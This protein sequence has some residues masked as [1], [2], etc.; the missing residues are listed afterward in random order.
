[1]EFTLREQDTSMALQMGTAHFLVVGYAKANLDKS[2][3]TQK[4]GFTKQVVGVQ[5]PED[6]MAWK[7]D[8]HPTCYVVTPILD[9]APEQLKFY[10]LL[11]PGKG[12][13]TP[14]TLAKD[15]VFYRFE[16][17]NEEPNATKRRA[18]W[19]DLIA[20]QSV[21]VGM[22]KTPSAKQ[23]T[24]KRALNVGKVIVES[25][26]DFGNEM[27]ILALAF[28]KTG[29]KDTWIL[30][31]MKKL[32]ERVDVDLAYRPHR[33]NK[34]LRSFIDND[35]V[36]FDQE[37]AMKV[38]TE[39]AALWPDVR[40]MT[41]ER[42]LEL[43]RL[44]H[45]HNAEIK[46][47]QLKGLLSEG[48]HL[49][50]QQADGNETTDEAGFVRGLS[51]TLD[52]VLGE[53]AQPKATA[54]NMNAESQDALL[55]ALQGKLESMLSCYYSFSSQLS[56]QFGDHVLEGAGPADFWAKYAEAP[57]T[58]SARL[59]FNHVAKFLVAEFSHVL[60][61]GIV[62]PVHDMVEVLKRLNLS[63]N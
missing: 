57:D 22:Q 13:C 10:V 51:A 8:E 44:M 52:R 11:L 61:E 37:D 9:L 4:P 12:L 39:V 2:Y 46:A 25:H 16:Y 35:A 31:E 36:D 7:D 53:Q 50:G 29:L 21:R 49:L 38:V 55:A 3:R 5:A 42:V 47:F 20:Q 28:K 62:K 6:I 41:P 59:A 26:E 60:N 19:R 34:A 56:S 18:A 17:R 23:E 58:D 14:Y 15:D 43:Q 54:S 63:P 30:K 48:M 27:K 45:D 33:S 1:M 24:F 32:L 40:G